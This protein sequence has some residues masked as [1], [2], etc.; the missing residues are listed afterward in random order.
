MPRWTHRRTSVVPWIRPSV[1]ARAFAA[2]NAGSAPPP[3]PAQGGLGSPASTVAEP[4][5]PGAASLRAIRDG[6]GD[7]LRASGVPVA[8]DGLEAESDLQRAAHDRPVEFSGCL[9]AP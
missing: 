8:R 2:Q 1:I 7:C 5:T 4:A 6:I 3:A 9:P